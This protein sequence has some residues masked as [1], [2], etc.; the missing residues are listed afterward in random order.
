[1]SML[2]RSLTF[3]AIVMAATQLPAQQT[4]KFTMAPASGLGAVGFAS[5]IRAAADTVDPVVAAQMKKD[6][7]AIDRL[8]KLAAT[9]K[10]IDSVRQ[11]SPKTEPDVNP[12]ILSYTLTNNGVTTSIN[13]TVIPGTGDPTPEFVRLLN[14]S[15]K[16]L[17]VIKKAGF[18]PQ[19]YA[20]GILG[21]HRAILTQRTKTKL[22]KTTTEGAPITL[23]A[24]TAPQ[25]V[26]RLVSM[27]RTMDYG[28]TFWK[29]G[30]KE[31]LM[32]F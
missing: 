25:E 8:K 26:V 31:P 10:Q 32:D 7:L 9:Q 15:P 19:E 18:T 29:L 3:A 13:D 27:I 5:F 30:L 1:M 17:A 6:S 21:V 22:G 28:R 20:E 14:S 4:S 11:S 23:W 12:S 2:L 24:S 16:M